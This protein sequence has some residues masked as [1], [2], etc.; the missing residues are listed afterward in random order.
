MKTNLISKKDEPRLVTRHFLQSIGLLTIFNFPHES[1]ILDLGT[2]GGFPGLPMKI[3][4]SDLD[5]VL[6]EA[7]Q[8]KALFLEEIIRILNL[9]NVVTI[10]KRVE[11]IKNQIAPADFIISRAVA[12]L[13]LLVRW[14]IACLKT[15]GG[16][17]IAIKGK[18]VNQEI[19][20]LKADSRVRNKI[21]CE[22]LSYNPFPELFILRDSYVVIIRKL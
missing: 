15:D 4:R 16:R 14:S 7:T 11:S 12:N 9:K 5:L 21:S 6:V 17:W 13:N 1:R 8:K 2:G 20:Q 18:C 19:K 22:V 3:I 10:P